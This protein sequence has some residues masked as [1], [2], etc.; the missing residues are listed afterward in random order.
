MRGHKHYLFQLID[1]TS[2]EG[3]ELELKKKGLENIYVIEDDS[4]GETLI[5]GHSR[6]KIS[7]LNALQLQAKSDVDWDEQWSQFAQ[8]YKEGKAHIDLSPF[9][10][11]C[12]LLLNPGPG[13]G[14]LSH[15]TTYLMLEMM[16]NHVMNERV[17]DIGTGSGILSLAASLLGAKKTT[18]IDIDKAAIK[19]AKE[20]GALNQI[21]NVAFSL[22]LPKK[23]GDQNIF[24]MNM[25]LPEQQEFDPQRLNPHAKLWIV[26]GIL[27][28][29]KKE[30][31]ALAQSWKWEVLQEFSRSDWM[32]WIFKVSE[33]LR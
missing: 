29:Q 8:D 33:V 11:N 16:K 22:S 30:Y 7:T 28:N 18:G 10:S 21:E 19:H 17:I 15:P 26:S 20:N 4:T 24:L 25:I 13:F 6:K 14:D 5:G 3:L 1:G 9:G 32:G 2:L 23:L 27:K 31:L 12:T